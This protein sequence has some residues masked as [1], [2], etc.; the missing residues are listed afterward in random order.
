MNQQ[1]SQ[2]QF[3]SAG[4]LELVPASRVLESSATLAIN[5][6]VARRRAE[7]QETLH[8]GFGEA[9]FPLH[10]LLRS[11]LAEA[12]DCTGYDPVA[13]SADLRQAI[14]GYIERTRGVNCSAEQVVV[15]PGSKPLL[16]GLLQVLAGDVLLPVPSWVSYKPQATFA[17]RRVMGVVTDPA[18]HH[19]L[20]VPAL[21]RAL[22]TARGRGMHPR[23]L[24][25][26]SP[27]NPT[28]GMFADEDVRELAT[29]AREQGLALIS[30]EI[31]A[32]L[33]HG[34]RAHVSPLPFYPEGC[35]LTGGLSKAFSIG[36][37]RLGYAVLPAGAQGQELGRAVQA[38]ASEIWSAVATPVA[39]AAVTAF[40]PDKE[41]S[42]YV[43][44]SARLHGCV[45]GA[46]RE[47]LV[48]LGVD[49][50]R[51]AGGFYL[52]P[53]FEPWRAVLYGLGITGSQD[54][55]RYLLDQWG[56][57]TL[58][59]VVFGEEPEAL[60]LRL[61]TSKLYRPADDSS[62]EEQNNRLW[63]LLSMTDLLAENESKI[64]CELPEL[65]RAQERWGE[66]IASLERL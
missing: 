52:Y 63:Q 46:L 9:V 65:A 26:N 51:P 19:R 20:T 61:A 25:V 31:Y 36:G 16:Y 4:P 59:G 64:L 37:W 27:S 8:L 7:G 18:D 14:A 54:L 28:G 1:Y 15:G 2:Q 23:I 24:V 48:T 53:D 58:P 56:V 5:E 44:R 10:P 30:D 33:A 62:A 13:G 43:R 35:I 41:L 29:W 40:T 45:T 38:L 21:T 49:C 39:R 17:G 55:A 66:V 11:A 60:R 22:E 34:W 47:T 6:A 12:A 42:A 57:A 32:D 50:P 3:A